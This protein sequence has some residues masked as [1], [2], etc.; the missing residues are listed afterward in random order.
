M[1]E[2]PGALADAVEDVAEDES[3][4]PDVVVFDCE[5]DD[6]GPR[7]G[8]ASCRLALGDGDAA[9][10][11]DLGVAA[12]PF[13]AVVVVVPTVKRADGGP[14]PGVGGSSLLIGVRMLLIWLSML[15]VAHCSIAC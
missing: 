4:E 7:R 15:R 11:A 9:R 8:A 5:E 2:S 13:S 12:E 14:L 6:G 1:P 10:L 3:G